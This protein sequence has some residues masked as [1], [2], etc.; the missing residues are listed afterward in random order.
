MTVEYVGCISRIF[1]NS[2]K[3]K[4]RVL[5][6]HKSHTKVG[7]SRLHVYVSS[8]SIHEKPIIV[9]D[10]PQDLPPA[11]LVILCGKVQSAINSGMDMDVVVDYCL[12]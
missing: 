10:V 8:E 9:L 1:M 3:L 11:E 6:S 12:L 7:T 2:K 4:R 5:Y